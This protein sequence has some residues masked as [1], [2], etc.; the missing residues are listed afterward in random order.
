MDNSTLASIYDRYLDVELAY[1]A[2]H[3]YPAAQDSLEAGGV[4]KGHIIEHALPGHEEAVH[5]HLNRILELQTLM[6]EKQL[7]ATE[8]FF[9]H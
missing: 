5:F 1:L 9:I 2:E 7:L 8:E 3:L 4:S 6:L